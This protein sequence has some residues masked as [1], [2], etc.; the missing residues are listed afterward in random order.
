MMKYENLPFWA[1]CG[2]MTSMIITIL[3]FIE[4][5]Y[6]IIYQLIADNA[7]SSIA[8][9]NTINPLGFSFVFFNSLP[10]NLTFLANLDSEVLALIILLAI[11]LVLNLIFAFILGSI[12]GFIVKMTLLKSSSPKPMSN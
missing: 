5:L 7:I 4:D 1:K 6:I 11:V 8:F 3:T 12:V 2:V 10:L 9:I